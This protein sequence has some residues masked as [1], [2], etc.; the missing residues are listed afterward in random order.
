MIIFVKKILNF[1]VWFMYS[2]YKY[3]VGKLYVKFI[4]IVI[5]WE[6]VGGL[7]WDEAVSFNL[8]VKLLY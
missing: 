4:L 3:L 2:R 7:E 5:S 8:T 6:G 1:S